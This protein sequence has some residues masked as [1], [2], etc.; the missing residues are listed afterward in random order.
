MEKRHSVNIKKL[1]KRRDKKIKVKIIIRP[2][3]IGYQVGS[4]GDSI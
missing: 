4:V 2:Y 3:I 1:Y